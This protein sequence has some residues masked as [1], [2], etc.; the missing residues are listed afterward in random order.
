MS[1][2]AA[3]VDPVLPEMSC[4]RERQFLSLV[5][6]NKQQ[7]PT[8]LL[9]V[10]LLISPT[11]A[12][13]NYEQGN[14][15]YDNQRTPGHYAIHLQSSTSYTRSKQ[16]E[17]YYARALCTGFSHPFIVVKVV[18]YLLTEGLIFVAIRHTNATYV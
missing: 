9:P 16:P 7:N 4:C 6:Q 15:Q 17:E 8:V 10:A 12:K 1:P 5:C 3:P 18:S 14:N 11:P 13:T 2:Q